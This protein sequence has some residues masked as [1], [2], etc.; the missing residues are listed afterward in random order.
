VLVFDLLFAVVVLVANRDMT[1][2]LV[3]RHLERP[4]RRPVLSVRSDR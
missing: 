4:A 3:D 1:G 2:R